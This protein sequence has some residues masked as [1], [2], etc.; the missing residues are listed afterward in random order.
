MLLLTEKEK[1]TNWSSK[2]GPK[3]GERS[4]LSQLNNEKEKVTKQ[5]THLHIKCFEDRTVTYI[6]F[7]DP[8]FKTKTKN[9][10]PQKQGVESEHH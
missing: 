1:L 8:K 4:H 5:N 9:K 2:Q 6:F 3:G 7:L 10:T